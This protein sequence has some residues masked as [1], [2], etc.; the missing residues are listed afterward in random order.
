MA[1]RLTEVGLVQEAVHYVEVIANT[2]AKHPSNYAPHFIQ[3][4]YDLG[5]MLKYFDPVYNSSEAVEGSVSDPEWLLHLLNILND[6]QV[7]ALFRLDKYFC[8]LS[9]SN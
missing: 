9:Y 7:L 3:E 1:R 4:V 8:C 6:Y 2:I 5:N